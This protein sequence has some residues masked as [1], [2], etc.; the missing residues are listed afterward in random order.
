MTPHTGSATL[1]NDRSN[2]HSVIRL[3]ASVSTAGGADDETVA[4]ILAGLG[5]GQT[6]KLL[7]E[8]S[9]SITGG[10]FSAAAAPHKYDPAKKR[11]NYTGPAVSHLFTEL[12][13][14][15]QSEWPR[16]SQKHTNG[17]ASFFCSFP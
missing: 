7:P 14:P 17:A 9:R 11:P 10:V 6:K 15:L 8:R 12:C 5:T 13:S 4:K 2:G 1:T 16:P 3:A